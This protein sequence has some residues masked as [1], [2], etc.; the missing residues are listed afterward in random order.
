VTLIDDVQHPQI[1]LSTAH[2]GLHPVSWVVSPRFLGEEEAQGKA[3]ARALFKGGRSKADLTPEGAWA[4]LRAWV[5]QQARVLG[6]QVPVCEGA[7]VALNLPPA[8]GP[9]QQQ[10]QA[11]ALVGASVA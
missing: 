7:L 5:E 11:E 9:P 2:V 4:A 1:P 8:P 10:Q 3:E 6:G